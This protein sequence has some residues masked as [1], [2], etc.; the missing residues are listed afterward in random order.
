M[1]QNAEV[2]T[3][4]ETPAVDFQ[5]VG[6]IFQ[7]KRESKKLSIAQVSAEIHVRQL[8][9]RAIEKGD[10]DV[11]PGHIYKVGFVK[12]YAAFLGVNV[13]AILSDLALL[14]EITPDYTSFTYSVPI[15]KQRKPGVKTTLAALT[16]LFVAG[17]ALYV[18]EEKMVHESEAASNVSLADPVNSPTNNSVAVQPETPIAA[19]PDLEEAAIETPVATTQDPV[20]SDTAL[21]VVAVKDA[22]VQVSDETGKA[23]FVRLMRAGETYTVPSDGHFKLNT[24]NGGGIKLSVGDKTSAIIGEEGKVIRGIDLSKDTVAKLIG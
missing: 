7:E 17:V 23:V 3:S 21:K 10:L 11:L 18:S 22:W 16:L 5:A 8:Y 2:L 20:V 19:V 9:L 13:K 15:E 14:E 24:G 6:K 1:T 4:V 12:N